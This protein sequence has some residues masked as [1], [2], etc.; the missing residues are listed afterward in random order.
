MSAFKDCTGL[1]EVI[2]PDSVLTLGTTVFQNCT[3]L[4]SITFG[5]GLTNIGGGVL[6]GCA[7]LKTIT[8]MATVPPAMNGGNYLTNVTEVRVPA[9]SVDSYKVAA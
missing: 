4:Q 7:A 2:I 6:N 9:E 3:S 1:T 8:C 5:A